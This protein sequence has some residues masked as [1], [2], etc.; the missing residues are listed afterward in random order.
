M[1]PLELVYMFL[2][3]MLLA[4]GTF[5]F[6]WWQVPWNE[7]KLRRTL[8]KKNYVVV[9]LRYGGGQLKP[10]V[11][12]HEE[13]VISIGDR[14]FTPDEKSVTY[15]GSIPIYVFN[16]NDMKPIAING[17]DIEDKYRDSE[18]V[19]HVMMKMKA[20]YEAKALNDI[21]LK[22][23]KVSKVQMF[24]LVGILASIAMLF[25]IITLVNAQNGQISALGNLVNS[26]VSGVNPVANQLPTG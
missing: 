20:Y 12:S 22:F 17:V 3:V 25:Y 5:L 18:Y 7:A 24:C 13:S 2:F 19:G 15:R 14:K 8:Q 10:H 26:L 16:Y 21:M 4:L 1:T 23:D 11:V 6:G 9:F